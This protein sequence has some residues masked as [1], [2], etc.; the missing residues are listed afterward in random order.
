MQLL[1]ASHAPLNTH[2]LPTAVVS[3]VD[4]KIHFTHWPFESQVKRCFENR[5]TM[6][7][8]RGAQTFKTEKIPVS[9][10]RCNYLLCVLNW[11][12]NSRSWIKKKKMEKLAQVINECDTNRFVLF[13]QQW[14]IDFVNINIVRF[15]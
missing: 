2:C 7:I 11:T 12:L 5:W 4:W 3:Q 9:M 8:D 6:I 15:D 14:K 10:L 13:D 1:Q